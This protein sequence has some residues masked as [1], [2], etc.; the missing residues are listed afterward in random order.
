VR[1]A[2]VVVEHWDVYPRVIDSKAGCPDDA[3]NIQLGSVGE[4]DGGTRHS[5]GS[6]VELDAVPTCATRT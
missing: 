3:A 1:G 4:G 6:A 5:D 2:A